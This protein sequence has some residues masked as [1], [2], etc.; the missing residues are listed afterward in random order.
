AV[1]TYEAL[2][3]G[4]PSVV[5]PQAGSVVRDGIEGLLVPPRD[6]DALADRMERLGRDPGLRQE[7]GSAARA[8]AMAFDW[9][10]YHD[11]LVDL[12]EECAGSRPIPHQEATTDPA[13]AVAETRG[14]GPRTI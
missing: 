8:R 4:L 1:V 3:S 14:R 12:V 5:T 10:R 7:M 11:A 13:W 9:P 2:A 6:V